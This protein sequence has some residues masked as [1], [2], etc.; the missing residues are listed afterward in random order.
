MNDPI[1]WRGKRYKT[2]GA[3]GRAIRKAYPR[4][5]VSV[6]DLETHAVGTHVTYIFDMVR[7]TGY[8]YICDQP[9][10]KR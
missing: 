2:F 7:Y 10:T 1:E 8:R 9:K 6:G 4:C 5:R 3:V